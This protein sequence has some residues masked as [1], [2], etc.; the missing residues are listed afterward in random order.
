M[1]SDSTKRNDQAETLESSESTSK[2]EAPSPENERTFG[3][4]KGSYIGDG[5]GPYDER[6]GKNPPQTSSNFT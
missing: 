4:E 1:K 5:S 6:G 3:L 2:I